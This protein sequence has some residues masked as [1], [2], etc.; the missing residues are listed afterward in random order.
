[1]TDRGLLEMAAKAAGYRVTIVS[2][3]ER[4]GMDFFYKEP[5]CLYWNPR[6]DDGD[7]R[8]LQVKL[9]IRVL[10]QAIES[11]SGHPNACCAGTFE[12]GEFTE[13]F[14][15]SDPESATR[16]AVLR[17]AAAIGEAME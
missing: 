15:D 16:L 10:F 17:A 1:M 7:S 5:E 14:E 3:H 8:R 13:M 4:D 9:G 12:H 2:I 11:H 6:N